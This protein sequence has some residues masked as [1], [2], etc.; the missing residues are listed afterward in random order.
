M[1]VVVL[2][3]RHG[4]RGTCAVKWQGRYSRVVDF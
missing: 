2:K 4:E 3:N 1:N